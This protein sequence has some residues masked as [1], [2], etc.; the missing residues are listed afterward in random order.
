MAPCAQLGPA[1]I[2]LR[3]FLGVSQALSGYYCH[4]LV[5][6][7]IVQGTHLSR[8]RGRS[9]SAPTSA[10]NQLR[11][12]FWAMSLR[13]HATKARRARF[14]PLPPHSH[15]FFLANPLPFSRPTFCL[16]FFP[17]ANMSDQSGSSHL[18]VLFEA[19]LRDYERK[20]GIALARHPLAEQ[21]QNCDSVDSV[22]AVLREQMKALSESRGK[23]KVLKPL[24]EVVSALHNLSSAAKF[25][26][27]IGL[28]RTWAPTGC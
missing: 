17:I 6:I 13:T 23:D 15:H 14:N 12:S 26:Q 10:L 9:T 19:G 22:T 25:G 7:C 28:V 1:E 5:A 2:F 16:H 27:D 3:I 24:K 21:L 4:N 11:P 8:D 20:T 18:Q